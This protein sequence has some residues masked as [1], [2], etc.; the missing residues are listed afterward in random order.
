MS[1][2][3]IR[4]GPRTAPA[5]TAVIA[6]ATVFA[7]GSAEPADGG[8]TPRLVP[9]GATQDESAPAAVTLVTVVGCLTEEPGELPWI[10]ERATAGE[11]TEQAFT[12]EEELARSAG[13]T[14]GSLRYRLLGVGEFGVESHVGHRV[15]AKGLKLRYDDELR[16]N[17]TSFQHLAPTC[18]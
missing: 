3:S 13:E 1:K 15:Q 4:T 17:I 9:G 16:L 11:P 8:T 18:E 7:L 5:T 14:L 10:L 6:L 2:L 12:T